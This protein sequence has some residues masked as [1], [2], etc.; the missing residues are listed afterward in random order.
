MY[1]G[2]HVNHMQNK[3]LKWLQT[4]GCL[5]WFQKIHLRICT[6]LYRILWMVN[7]RSFWSYLLSFA[8][9]YFE[10]NRECLQALAK[11]PY[12]NNTNFGECLL[13]MLNMPLLWSVADT[14]GSWVIDTEVLLDVPEGETVEGSVKIRFDVTGMGSKQVHTLTSNNNKIKQRLQLDRVSQGRFQNPK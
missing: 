4:S 14:D 1:N 12:A 3:I 2:L 11:I 9:M 13:C 10:F 8:Y 6:I 7:F 5:L